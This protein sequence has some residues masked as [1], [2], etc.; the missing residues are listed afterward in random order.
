[1]MNCGSRYVNVNR[2]IP[3]GNVVVHTP[4]YLHFTEVPFRTAIFQ[5]ENDPPC[6]LCMK[7]DW[8]SSKKNAVCEV[9]THAPFP[10]LGPKP[11]ALDHSAKTARNYL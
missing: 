3:V 9:R 8:G 7:Y 11:N 4:M 1:M 10:R 6:L 5:L 2:C